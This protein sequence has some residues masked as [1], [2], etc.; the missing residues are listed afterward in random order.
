MGGRTAFAMMGWLVAAAA[1]TVVGL[2]AVRVIGD[3]ITGT[4]ATTLSQ[5]E[6]VEA[7]ASP[8]PPASPPPTASPS[9][10]PA[11]TEPARTTLRP[12]GSTIT[13]HCEGAL[14]RIDGVAPPSG[15]QTTEYDNE[16]TDEAEVRFDRGGKGHGSGRIEVQVSCV[17]GRP[18]ATA[19]D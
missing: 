19:D 18:L 1:A 11:R 2:G 6:V 16:L 10:T 12:H 3:G 5:E 8:V 14:V 9:P 4:A 7:L 17:N 15:Y 13:A